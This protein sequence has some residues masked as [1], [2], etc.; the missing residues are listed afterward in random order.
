MAQW[1]GQY[2]GNSH[3]T[4]VDDLEEILQHAVI[5]F[6]NSDSDLE[7]NS[8]KK[9]LCKL[10]KKLYNARLKL[11]RAKLDEAQPV[12]EGDLETQSSRIEAL[13]TQEAKVKSEGINGIF[14]EFG[15]K[16]LISIMVD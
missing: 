9:N 14:V 15:I 13:R 11:L 8:K 16:E 10:A 5:V 2:S 4:K 7:R 3:Q 1:W 12:I 6:H